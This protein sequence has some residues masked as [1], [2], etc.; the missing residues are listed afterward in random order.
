MSMTKDSRNRRRNRLPGIYWACFAAG[1][2]ALWS[3]RVVSND[4]LTLA[5]GTMLIWAL[6]L[7]ARRY[8]ESR[9]DDDEKNEWVQDRDESSEP[10]E[11]P[12][13]RPVA[14]CERPKSDGD[15]GHDA[16]VEQMLAQGR[17]PLLLRPQIAG[18]LKREPFQRALQVLDE[19][20][21]LVPDG[22]VVLGKVDTASQDVPLH[23]DA[24]DEMYGWLDRRQ[25]PQTG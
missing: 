19:G 14:A 8:R 1:L 25:D 10:E 9:A 4:I 16:L 12:D 21:A 17:Y 5:A 22:E 6:Y 2:V 13:P 24:L 18:E 23:N 7:L 3:G 15:N 20:M 11:P